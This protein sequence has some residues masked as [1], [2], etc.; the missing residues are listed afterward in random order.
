MRVRKFLPALFLLAAG[1]FIMGAATAGNL[2][3]VPD[4]DPS[5]YDEQCTP[6]CEA[7][8]VPCNKFSSSEMSLSCRQRCEKERDACCTKNGK[9][10]GSSAS[11]HCG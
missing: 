5:T 11:C 8:K 7:C 3:P 6:V 4:A 9:G 2:A 10:I 1:I